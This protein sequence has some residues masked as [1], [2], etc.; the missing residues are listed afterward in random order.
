[1]QITNLIKKNERQNKIKR[2]EHALACHDNKMPNTRG[3]FPHSISFSSYI[4]GSE[5]GPMWFGID[6]I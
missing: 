3:Q 2:K 4:S 1:M 6:S 5:A